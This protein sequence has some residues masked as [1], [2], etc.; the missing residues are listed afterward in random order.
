MRNKPVLL[1]L[2]TIMLIAGITCG[3]FSTA[4]AA[5]EIDDDISPQMTYISTISP[6]LSI[7]GTAASL[8]CEVRGISGTTTKITITGTL[9]RYVSNRW[10][11]VSS[12]SQTENYYRMTYSRNTSVTSGY[13]YRAKYTVKAYAG[14]TYETR[15]VYSKIVSIS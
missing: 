6:Y 2:L 3:S 4:L 9:Q 11:N 7:S 5:D 15:T 1:V 14:S 10:V 13:S 12:T 8:N